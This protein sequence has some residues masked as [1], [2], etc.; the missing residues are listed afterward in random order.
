MASYIDSIN[1]VNNLQKISLQIDSKKKND[2]S[3]GRFS[4]ERMLMNS[5]NS[6][7]E[8]QTN[9]I[10]LENNP[11]TIN[12]VAL[13]DEK[14]FREC[15]KFV[16]RHE[17]KKLVNRDGASGESS[18][19]G[20]LQSTARSFG[21]KGEIRNITEKQAEAIYKKLWEKSGAKDLSFPMS[22]V[23]FDTYVNSPAAARKFLA[24]SNGDIE[25]YIKSR[26]QRYDRL[27]ELRP[28][29]FAKYLKGWKARINNL[30]NAVALSSVNFKSV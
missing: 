2:L 12:P 17:G 22:L 30:S 11:A 4:F 20:I 23:H 18:K 29:T 6:A 8:K 9:Y 1:P 26:E 19:Y 25:T 14:K 21:Y 27:A 7:D 15:L 3:T 28:K 24:R 10:S 16:I 5:M 13:D